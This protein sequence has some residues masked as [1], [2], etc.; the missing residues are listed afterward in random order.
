MSIKYPKGMEPIK[1]VAPKGK[2]TQRHIEGAAN[3][4]MDFESDINATCEYYRQQDIAI[5]TKRPT[6]INIVRVDYSRGAKIT[7]AYFE[8]QS[9][10]DY[11]GVYKG[12]YLDFEAKQTH[13]KTSFPLNNIAPQQVTHLEG[14]MRNGGIAF[15]LIRL[16]I[17]DEVYLLDAYYVC[18]FYREKPRKSI[19]LEQIRLNGIKVKEAYSPRYDFLAALDELLAKR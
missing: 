12:L 15:F 16:S 5:I 17:S 9:T 10:T 13:S 8:K 3:R 11:N 4:G 7:D 14:V 2:K 6:P 1:E 19:P 18:R